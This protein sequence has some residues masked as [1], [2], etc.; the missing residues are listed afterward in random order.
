MTGLTSICAGCGK[1]LYQGPEPAERAVSHGTCIPCFTKI[2]HLDGDTP[3]EL[4]EFV[5]YMTTEGF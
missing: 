5:N 4:T 1:V 2:M 3:E